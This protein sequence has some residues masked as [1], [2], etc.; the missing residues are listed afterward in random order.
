MTNP[1][2]LPLAWL[3]FAT[4]AGIKGWRL[5][6]LLRRHLLDAPS[7]SQR[8]RQSLERIWLQE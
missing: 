1:T 8:F 2:D 6:S 4:A 7:P 3:V 5:I